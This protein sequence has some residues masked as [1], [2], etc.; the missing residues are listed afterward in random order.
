MPFPDS[1]FYQRREKLKKG[2]PC[3]AVCIKSDKNY[4]ALQY[5]TKF[6][7]DRV[8]IGIPCHLME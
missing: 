1:E 8:S 7:V 3:F 5:T 2:N 4:S 6:F